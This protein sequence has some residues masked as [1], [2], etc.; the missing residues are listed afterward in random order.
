MLMCATT[1]LVA[2]TQIDDANAEQQVIVADP[3]T[4]RAMWD[5]QFFLDIGVITGST[6]LAPVG[7]DGTYWFALNGILQQSINLIKTAPIMSHSPSPE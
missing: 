5:V 6:G 2:G 7:F 1:G 4:N 3:A